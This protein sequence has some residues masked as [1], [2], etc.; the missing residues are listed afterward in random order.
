EIDP[1]DAFSWL[2]LARVQMQQ[3]LT[4]DAADSIEK[5]VTVFSNRSDFDLNAAVQTL[6]IFE[7]ACK[8]AGDFE[9]A[10]RLK[11]RSQKIMA[12]AQPG[13]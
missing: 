6:G 2:S 3:R 5:F 13:R 9:S 7:L 8:N 11:A 1:D 10:E 4:K 12:E